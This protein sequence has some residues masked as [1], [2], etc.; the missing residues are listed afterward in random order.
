MTYFKKPYITNNNSTINLQLLNNSNIIISITYLIN[1]FDNYSKNIQTMLLKNNNIYYDEEIEYGDIKNFK[2]I[3]ELIYH[4]NYI[5]LYLSSQ[6][7]EI[8]K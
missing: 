2:T 1:K 8:E 7:E 6:T 5:A 3:D 4:L